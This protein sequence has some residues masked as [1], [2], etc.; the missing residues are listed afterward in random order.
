MKILSGNCRDISRPTAVR[1]FRA[2]IRSNNPDILFLSETKSPLSLTSSIFNRLGLYSM[3]HVAPIGSCG[4]LVLTWRLGVELKSFLT[5]KNNITTWCFSD[6]P[7]HPWI[8]SCLSG[9]LEKLN[10]PAFWDSFIA[11][12]ENFVNPWL[13]IEDFNFILDQSKKLGGRPVAG[14]S[15]CPFRGFID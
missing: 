14:S 11:V 15:H 10:K 6:L 1:G 5:K 7:N 4:V 2:L 3:T 13:Y 9:P 8:L 12:G